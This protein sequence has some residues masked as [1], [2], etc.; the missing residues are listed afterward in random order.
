M[1]LVVNS[2]TTEAP[3]FSAAPVWKIVVGGNKLS[4][5]YTIEGL[6]VSYYRRVAGTADTLMQMGRW[7]GFRPGYQDLVRVFLGVKEGKKGSND[8]VALFKEV[9]RMEERFREEIKRYVR[10]P[11]AKRITPREIPPMI[12]V[13]GSLPPT[14]GNK[15]FNAL[16]ASKN[17][18]GRWSMLTL[19]PTQPGT[20]DKNIDALKMLFG[21]STER[22]MKSLGG[23]TSKGKK[24]NA[25]MFVFEA[26]NAQLVAF[27]KAYRWL[28]TDY[29][30]PERPTDASLQIEF[31]ERQKHGITSWLI[32]A[33]QRKVSF[34]DPAE[35]G[36][37]AKL[38]VKTRQR[39]EGR[40]F[41]VFGEPDHRKIAEFL[42]RIEPEPGKS[43]L[44]SQLV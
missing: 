40:S 6:T 2:D 17:F 14:A 19:A 29:K 41:Q 9:C 8:L 5:G 30:Y 27:L 18:G 44:T 21:S 4:R 37:F 7:F 25:E 20:M 15:M 10:T 34:G 38:A 26:T 11:G 28:E 16:L 33:P 22:G 42:C 35:M 36:L 24:I 39:V 12:A 43:G 31:L 23:V 3:D 1:F 32:I 13:S